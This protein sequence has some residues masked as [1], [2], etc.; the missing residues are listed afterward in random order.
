LAL[1]VVLQLISYVEWIL[2]LSELL[3]Q[4]D[5][6]DSL[7]TQGQHDLWTAQ[8]KVLHVIKVLSQLAELLQSTL[9]QID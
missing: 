3:E 2:E 6:P 9:S 8:L 7:M 4:S 5:D 1:V